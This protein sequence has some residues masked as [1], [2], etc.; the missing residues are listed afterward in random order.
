MADAHIE[1]E[2]PPLEL[3]GVRAAY[4]GIEVLH[5]IDL[6]V[7]G[8]EVVALLGANGAG[9]STTVKVAAG[10]LRADRAARSGWP[11]TT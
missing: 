1:A 3:V 10:L 2:V 8:G 4:G 6:A 7:H 5:G 11:G 9:K